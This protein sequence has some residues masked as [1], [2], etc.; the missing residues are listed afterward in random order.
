LSATTSDPDGDVISHWWRVKKR[1]PGSRVV[2]EKQGARDTSV[3]GL[4]VEGPYVF[5]LTVVDR[6]RFTRKAVTL[7]VAGK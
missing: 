7:T 5:E 4:T 1:P 6:T 3:T 2:F